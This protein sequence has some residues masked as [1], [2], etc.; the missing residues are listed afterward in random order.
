MINDD[1]QP[2]DRNLTYYTEGAPVAEGPPPPA[3]E[4]VR[5]AIETLAPYVA[6]VGLI[7]AYYKRK[8]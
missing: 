6:R 2:Y 3:D 4:K 8:H 7:S 1:H 5:H